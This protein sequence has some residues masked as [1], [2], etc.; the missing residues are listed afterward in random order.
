MDCEQLLK[1]AYDH[2]QQNGY[3]SREYL[4]SSIQKEGQTYWVFFQGISGLPGDHFS[5]N[6]DA[7]TQKATRL[8]S[9][10]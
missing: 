1:I 3:N 2:G 6:V 10:R 9:G 7:D 5:V 4:V 8:I